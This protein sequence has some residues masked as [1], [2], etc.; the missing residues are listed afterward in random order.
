M[1]DG[2]NGRPLIL[3][4]RNP[5]CFPPIRVDLDHPLNYDGFQFRTKKTIT[6]LK[7][8]TPTILVV[9]GIAVILLGLSGSV[10]RLIDAVL[11]RFGL[12]NDLG[13]IT[14]G[15]APIDL[16]MGNQPDSQGAPEINVTLAPAVKTKFFIATRTPNT[17]APHPSQSSSTVTAATATEIP[18]T[19]TVVPN[20]PSRLQIPSIGLDA[21]VIPAESSK[22]QI[23]GETFNQ[24]KA[25]D[26]FAVGWH[27]TSAMLGEVGNTVLNGHHNINGK[28][29]EN[30][31]N[32][33]AGDEVIVTG[34]DMQYTYIV[35][36]VM[37]LPERN[38]DLATRLDNAR[39]ILPS[40]DERLTMITCWPATSNTHRL[41]VVAQPI[42]I[43]TLIQTPAAT[44]QETVTPGQ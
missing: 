18:P 1:T 8:L 29:F 14:M 13:E 36:N 5:G 11:Q 7:K 19:P 15:F 33:V 10:P 32:V 39:W 38:V 43:P 35:V 4:E 40:N 22:V 30:L 9:I 12:V 3:S 6:A 28:V 23:S 34:G 16:P 2:L 31:H 21:P 17:L 26:E 41:I 20:I 44:G 24:W 42:G 37:I 25:P 27:T